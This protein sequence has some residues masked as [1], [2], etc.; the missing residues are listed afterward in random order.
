MKKVILLTLLYIPTLSC[1]DKQPVMRL[2]TIPENTTPTITD[3][4]SDGV[5]G[6]SSQASKAQAQR[7]APPLETYDVIADEVRFYWDNSTSAWW[8][9]KYNFENYEKDPLLCELI[10]GPSK[11]I[12]NVQKVY[13]ALREK[14][15]KATIP[16]AKRQA[17]RQKAFEAYELE[18]K[19]RHEAQAAQYA[20]EVARAAIQAL[21]A[22]QA[23][24]KT[25]CCK[26]CT[27]RCAGFFH[28]LCSFLF[29]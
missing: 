7:P 13:N 24:K 23:P 3:T 12:E 16:F 2:L 15:A 9:E 14:E 5:G 10:K 28:N 29:S 25:T 8:N 4:I 1:A 11:N 22:Q 17:L 19:I 27:K 21:A 20:Q 26:D 18:R 6:E